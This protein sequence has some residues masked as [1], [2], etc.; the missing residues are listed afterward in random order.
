MNVI[1]RLSKSKCELLKKFQKNDNRYKKG[2][3]DKVRSDLLSDYKG[4]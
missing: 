1:I 2:L 4:T 3:E